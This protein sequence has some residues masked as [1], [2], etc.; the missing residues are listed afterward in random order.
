MTER[1]ISMQKVLNLLAIEG[2]LESLYRICKIDHGM[3]EKEVNEYI[4]NLILK[5]AVLTQPI[6]IPTEEGLKE[7]GWTLTY[8]LIK[9]DLTA[10]FRTKGRPLIW[11]DM[12]NAVRALT[13][14]MN[15]E[16]DDFKIIS[17]ATAIGSRY[18]LIVFAYT[19]GLGH[20]FSEFASKITTLLP[21]VEVVTHPFISLLKFDPVP[22]SQT[23]IWDQVASDFDEFVTRSNISALADYITNEKLYLDN[24]IRECEEKSISLVEI[25]SGT[26]RLLI[27]Y[28]QPAAI[29]EEYKDHGNDPSV[30]KSVAEKVRL[31]VGVESS[32]KMI[33]E[34]HRNL[35]K[36][37]LKR[38]ADQRLFL[39][40]ARSEYLHYFISQ[41]LDTKECIALRKSGF[42][43]DKRIVC[44]M[45][46]TLG[47]M[48]R[49]T[50]KCS[51]KEM[52]E[53]AG[54]NGII[55]ISVFDGSRF[56]EGV[57]KIYFPLSKFVG[58]FR[59]EINIDYEKRVFTTAKGYYS[60]WFEENELEDLLKEE[61][62]DIVDLK[63]D[64]NSLAIFIKAV[65]RRN[66]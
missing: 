32:E 20:G 47:I 5:K 33:D 40:K 51:I 46:N 60:H 11:V 9:L 22:Y 27:R 14:Y 53:I 35:E 25:G 41:D 48:N 63:R 54:E 66:K 56:A 31:V 26:G 16:F 55:V 8:F 52:K 19:K 62:L 43:E 29:E 49:K 50:R 57:E 42:W 21:T 18:D 10:A 34:T 7:L 15:N 44:A 61:D 6:A 36:A 28:L 4:K 39:F 3:T 58:D 65:P 59:P 24:V 37:N 30:A 12:G 23:S 2:D 38:L 1:E 45:L 13:T 17:I 64:P